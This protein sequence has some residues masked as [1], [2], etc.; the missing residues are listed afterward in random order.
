M[1]IYGGVS[2]RV[3]KNV[4][5]MSRTLFSAVVVL[6]VVVVHGRELL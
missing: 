4:G 5:I 2:D 1:H 6:V 3:G